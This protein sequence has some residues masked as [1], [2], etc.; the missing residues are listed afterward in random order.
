MSFFLLEN[1]GSLALVLHMDIVLR[2]FLLLCFPAGFYICFFF[3]LRS[4]GLQKILS[5]IF[6][7]L[8]VVICVIIA[9]NNLTSSNKEIRRTLK[10]RNQ[11]PGLAFVD[12]LMN[13]QEMI[14]EGEIDFRVRRL[15]RIGN[16]PEYPMIN[17]TLYSSPFP[18]PIKN[19]RKQFYNTPN[20][21]VLFVES[22]SARKLS[23]Y[24][25]NFAQDAPSARE[26][27][28]PNLARFARQ[29]MT[30]EHYFS[31]TFSTFRGLRGQNC[32]MFPYHGGDGGWSMPGFAPP[33]GPYKCL[34]HHLH[35]EGYETIFCGPDIQEHCH[36][37]FQA[38]QIGFKDNIFRREIEE[39]YLGHKGR[40]KLHLTDQELMQSLVAFLQ[41]KEANQDKQPFYLATYPKGCHVG[42]N[43]DTDGC[44]YRG[45]K[46]RV[47][48]TM[49]SWDQAF[50]VFWDAFQQLDLAQETILVVTGDHSHWPERPY[51]EIAGSDYS[52]QCFEEMGLF[53]Y[54]PFH[55]LPRRYNAE[56][57]TSLGFAPMITQ[58]LALEP[59]Q[60]NSFLG[61][62]P[63]E[64]NREH[65]GVGWANRKIFLTESGKKPRCYNFTEQDSAKVNNLRQAIRLTHL[66]E[67]NGKMIYSQTTTRQL[68]Q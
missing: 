23:P 34:P 32:S 35:E 28:T 20:I 58:I 27:L 21:I 38:Q 6:L 22:L 67:L 56:H 13:V 49:H 11:S 59:G 29:A 12:A 15:I 50:G 19:D 44:P 51:I 62:S 9:D 8:L 63:F 17:E 66:A 60:K 18:F 3:S 65:A 55:D 57:A 52:R 41:Q 46:N 37:S 26:D 5:N 4:A 7:I 24:K 39:K 64:Q 30:V 42:L 14:A 33:T 61:I 36:F 25:E 31:H 10:I 40:S 47:L 16:I 2:F 45:G 53:I 48:N 43:C 54:S 1:I 68:S